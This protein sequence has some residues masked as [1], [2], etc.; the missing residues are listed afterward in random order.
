MNKQVYDF[1]NFLTRDANG[2]FIV[3]RLFWERGEPI[4]S[5]W[6][7]GIFINLHS[8]VAD[9]QSVLRDNAAGWDYYFRAPVP[10]DCIQICLDDVRKK[11]LIE[12]EEYGLRP[13]A[14]VETSCDSCHVWLRFNAQMDK[15]AGLNDWL[16][17]KFNTD[18]HS[19]GSNHAFRIPGVVSNKHGGTPVE[20]TLF[21]QNE[22]NNI[23]PEAENMKSGKNIQ[24]MVYNKPAADPKDIYFNRIIDDM[25]KIKKSKKCPMKE[26]DYD[27]NSDPDD[28]TILSWVLLNHYKWMLKH[29]PEQLESIR[30]KYIAAIEKY[31][32][33]AR[34]FSLK[35][36]EHKANRIDSFAVGYVYEHCD[37]QDKGQEVQNL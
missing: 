33:V 5:S 12:I 28:S 2:V 7:E 19:K 20:L 8:L 22:I 37:E 26:A 36:A 3:S 4:K 34:D 32:L 10:S 21:N 24:K 11:Q 14:I 13:F 30:S 35:A 29:R 23:P 16:V 9:W 31:Y 6:T 18:N 27:G 17:A 1:L 15:T 25:E